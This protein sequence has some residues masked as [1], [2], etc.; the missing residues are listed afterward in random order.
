[1]DSVLFVEKLLY[2]LSGRSPYIGDG[3]RGN[4]HP[5]HSVQGDSYPKR[6]P[7]TVAPLCLKPIGYDGMGGSAAPP[8]ARSLP[9]EHNGAGDQLFHCAFECFINPKAVT[10]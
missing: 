2:P 1:M 5:Q 6:A 10:A 9:L 4:P 3:G 8:D 7:N